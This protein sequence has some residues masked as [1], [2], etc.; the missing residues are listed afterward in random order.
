[1][2]FIKFYKCYIYH[3]VKK[4]KNR[5]EKFK[6]VNRTIRSRILLRI[7]NTCACKKRSR[8]ECVSDKYMS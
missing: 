6:T 5:F 2:S 1:M 4:K 8:N 3:R 7:Q